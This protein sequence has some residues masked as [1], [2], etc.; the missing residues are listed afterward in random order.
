MLFN[1]TGINISHSA[2]LSYRFYTDTE[3]FCKKCSE[4]QANSNGSLYS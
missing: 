2:S 1:V 4:K 3:G